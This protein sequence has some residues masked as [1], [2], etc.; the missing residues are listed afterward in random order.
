MLNRRNFLKACGVGVVAPS[1]VAL[2]GTTVVPEVTET[3]EIV[4]VYQEGIPAG[5]VCVYDDDGNIIPM[6]R[7]TDR[8]LFAGVM[9]SSGEFFKPGSARPVKCCYHKGFNNHA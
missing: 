3:V 2:G 6:P 8:F 7:E 1:L 4:E 5:T 9:G